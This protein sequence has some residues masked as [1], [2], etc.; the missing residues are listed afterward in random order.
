M[1]KIVAA[2][3]AIAVVAFV[4]YMHRD[5]LT[6]RMSCAE[7]IAHQF[8]T[9]QV[10]SGAWNCVP[11]DTQNAMSILAGIDTPAKFAKF[12]G[13]DG[14][15]YTY[16]GE[17][18]DEGYT[19]RF[20]VAISPHNSIGEAFSDLTNGDFKSIWPELNGDTQGWFSIVKTF[21]L[22]PQGSTIIN[23]KTGQ[24]FDVSGDLLAIK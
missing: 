13:V 4:G 20:D 17:T 21:Y 24:V 2:I 5:Q 8:T 7:K 14:A 10:V 9:T 19:Y 18:K 16:L 11:V 23:L 6:A 3:V 12:E 15:S 1:K 22:F